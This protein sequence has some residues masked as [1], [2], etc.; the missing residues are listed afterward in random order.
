MGM[1]DYLSR[2][3]SAAAPETSIYDKSFTVAKLKMIN[4][5][6]NPRDQLTPRGHKVKQIRKNP[7][8]EGGRSCWYS[9]KKVLSNEV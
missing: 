2:F 5:A 6:L 4:D 3:P 8:V 1:A 9:K 7:T